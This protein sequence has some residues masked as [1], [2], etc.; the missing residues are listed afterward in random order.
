MN[1]KFQGKELFLLKSFFLSTHRILA[2]ES[3]PISQPTEEEV[4]LLVNLDE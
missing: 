1:K 3:S 4:R 2:R